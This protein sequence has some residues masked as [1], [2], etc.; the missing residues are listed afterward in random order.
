MKKILI[1]GANGQIGIELTRHLR[2]IYGESNVTATD[3]KRVSGSFSEEGPF[4]I[5]DARDGAAAAALL[6]QTKADTVIHLAGVL[7]ATGEM[8]PQLAWDTN[9]NGL[10]T[11]LEAAR[12]R[13]CS[14]FFPSSIAAFGPGTPARN[15]PQDTLQRPETIYG[16]AKVAGELLC[17]YYH[18]K[19][20]M[21]TRGLRFP[22]LISYEA[23]PGGGTT[24]YAVHIYY[25]A[26]AKKEYR[27]YI[28]RGSFMDMMYMPD[29]LEAVVQLMEANPQKL[30]HRNAFNISAMSFDPEGI[31]GS[32][33]K[34]IPDFTL[35]YDV[36]PQ[37]QAIADSWPDSL[38]CSTAREEWGFSPKFDLDA[39]TRDMLTKLSKR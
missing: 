9:M 18:K 32:I 6:E 31:A 34:V 39:M 17:D 26:L 35:S 36:D 23:L 33:R 16:V 38:D 7:S 27:S 8:R 4:A 20:G 12:A 21:D 2:K 37:R 13:N 29:A 10:Y 14:F 19:Y 25:D 28:A 15:T 11:M 24:D 30:K 5:L 3:I 22:G 1:S